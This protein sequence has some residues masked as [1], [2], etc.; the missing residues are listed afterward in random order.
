M[1][2]RNV[3]LKKINEYIDFIINSNFTGREVLKREYLGVTEHDDKDLVIATEV[4][5]DLKKMCTDYK[6]RK[7]DSKTL[8][9]FCFKTMYS[10]YSP[11]VVSKIVD[12]EIFDSL[13]YISEL[14]F[15]LKKI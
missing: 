12:D 5:N 2:G 1:N 7:I 14:D 6:R 10:K 9:D 3:N 4:Y 8:S 15:N 13:D 11:K